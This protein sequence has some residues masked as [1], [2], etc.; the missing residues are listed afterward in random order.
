MILSGVCSLKYL[1]G[2]G[3]ILQNSHKGFSNFNVK[4]LSLCLTGM[5]LEVLLLIVVI[6]VVVVVVIIAVAAAF[7]D[8]VTKFL[9]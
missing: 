1:H 2:A 7:T 9:C 5:S 8:G 4:Y 3:W 6:A